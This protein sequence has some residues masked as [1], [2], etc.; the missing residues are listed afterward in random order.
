MSIFLPA[1]NA[2]VRKW[3][4]DADMTPR[5]T[6]SKVLLVADQRSVAEGAT[7]VPIR[8][9]RIARLRLDTPRTGGEQ[10]FGQLKRVYD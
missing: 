2:R 9:F 3:V 8:R 6:Q 5:H 10:R 7:P 4:D 1:A